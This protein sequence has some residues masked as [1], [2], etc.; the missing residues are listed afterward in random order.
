[1]F[2]EGCAELPLNVKAGI[3]FWAGD[4][5]IEAGQRQL[6]RFS[7]VPGHDELWFTSTL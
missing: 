1:M 6:T 5:F 7:L 2:L 4:A 3:C